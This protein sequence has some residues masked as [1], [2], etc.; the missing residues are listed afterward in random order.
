M[1]ILIS[2]FSSFCIPSILLDTSI[3]LLL[4]LLLI[5]L[6]WLHGPFS[7]T[8][9]SLLIAVHSFLSCAFI[10]HRLVPRAFK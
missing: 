6:L 1:K 4:L 5:F 9:A 8:L 7:L 2:Q 10:L 3:L